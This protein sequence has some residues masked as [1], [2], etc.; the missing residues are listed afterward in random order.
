VPV[1][2]RAESARRDGVR[3]FGES[4]CLA[5]GLGVIRAVDLMPLMLAHA[6]RLAKFGA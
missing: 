1:V 3:S 2:L 6:G 5:G 4:A